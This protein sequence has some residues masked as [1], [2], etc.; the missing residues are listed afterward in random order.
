M[1]FESLVNGGI[2][3]YFEW[4]FSFLETALDPSVPQ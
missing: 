4:I 2:C 3:G 1:A